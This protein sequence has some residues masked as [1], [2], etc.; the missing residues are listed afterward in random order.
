MTE[1]NA[2]CTFLPDQVGFRFSGNRYDL[3]Q[4]ST[5]SLSDQRDDLPVTHLHHVGAVHLETDGQTDG[6]V[7]V[8]HGAVMMRSTSEDGRYLYEEVSGP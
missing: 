1:T 3:H 7:K 4:Q 2:A 8:C 6:R 5:S